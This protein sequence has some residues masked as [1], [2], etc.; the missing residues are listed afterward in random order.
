MNVFVGFCLAMVATLGFAVLF[1]AP[2]RSLPFCAL[3]GG[4]A[5]LLRFGST[6]IGMSLELGTL[7]SAFAIGAIGEL[8]AR[9]YRVP[10][11]VFRV[12]GFIPLIPGRLAYETVQAM[13]DEQYVR[14]LEYAIQTVILAGAIAGGIGVATALF[15]LRRRV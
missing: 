8:A 12:T 4:I 5:W 15:R 13:L 2:Q 14:G 9:R 3:N 10:A 11:L 1:N 6:Q 7:I